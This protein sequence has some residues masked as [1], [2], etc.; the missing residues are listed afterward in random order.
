MRG[1]IN[2]S[3]DSSSWI[4][5]FP[6][7]VHSYR[8]RNGSKSWPRQKVFCKKENTE[9]TS[10]LHT[11]YRNQCV[12]SYRNIRPTLY[13]FGWIIF[14]NCNKDVQWEIPY[15]PF[16]TSFQLFLKKGIYKRRA[17]FHSSELFSRDKIWRIF[18][19]EMITATST[20]DDQS[21]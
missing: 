5:L 3:A 19:S 21:K 16:Y 2:T 7:C 6:I 15:F 4:F 13:K 18:Q 11:L 12:Y 20:A 8:S 14:C 10:T 17:V 1:I 9:N